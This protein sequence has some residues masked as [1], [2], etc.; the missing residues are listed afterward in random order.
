MSN[1]FGIILTIAVLAVIVL[2]LALLTRQRRVTAN[3]D[4]NSE[5]QGAIL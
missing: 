5:E 1:S 4:S 2:Q 3:T